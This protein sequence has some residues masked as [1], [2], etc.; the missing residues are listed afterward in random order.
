MEEEASLNTVGFEVTPINNNCANQ[1][2]I[3]QSNIS[4]S[5]GVQNNKQIDN[6]SNQ[7]KQDTAFDTVDTESLKPLYGGGDLKD[8]QIIFK[9]K[10]FFMKSKNIEEALHHIAKILKLKNHG[11]FETQEMNK[12]ISNNIYHYKNNKKPI[13][14]KIK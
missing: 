3:I 1:K 2:N 4:S 5:Q 8:Y 6:L 10:V 13:I 11:L 14:I 9:K 7:S 12:K